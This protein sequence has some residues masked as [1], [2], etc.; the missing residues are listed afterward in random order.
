MNICKYEPVGQHHAFIAKRPLVVQKRL[1]EVSKRYDYGVTPFQRTA[2]KFGVRYDI[3]DRKTFD[4]TNH[5]YGTLIEGGGFHALMYS[6]NRNNCTWLHYENDAPFPAIIPAGTKFFLGN[7]MDVVTRSLI[8]YRNM[9]ELEAVHGKM[10]T[11]RK[12]V[13]NYSKQLKSF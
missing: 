10:P 1:I 3:T 9:A 7:D 2:M 6:A 4:I 13:E 5:S 12:P 8:V 11:E